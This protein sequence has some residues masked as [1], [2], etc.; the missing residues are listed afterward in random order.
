MKIY[1]KANF[2]LLMSLFHWFR[3]TFWCPSQLSRFKCVNLLVKNSRESIFYTKAFHGYK[4]VF[5]SCSTYLKT[6]TT[7]YKDSF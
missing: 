6:K 5:T 2:R 7:Y 1:F 3:V 4:L